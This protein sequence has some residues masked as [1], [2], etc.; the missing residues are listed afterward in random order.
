MATE[1]N[2]NGRPSDKLQGLIQAVGKASTQEKR[3]AALQAVAAQYLIEYDAGDFALT[4]D[5]H[6]Y[7]EDYQRAQLAA[8]QAAARLG[9]LLVQT[10]I[11]VDEAQENHDND[12]KVVPLN[13][14]SDRNH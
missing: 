6:S 3:Q 13:R 11:A 7:V 4:D 12:P 2:E 14:R 1:M 10:M 9:R 5:W 8:D